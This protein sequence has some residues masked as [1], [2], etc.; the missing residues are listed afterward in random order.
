VPGKQARRGEHPAFLRSSI[1]QTQVTRTPRAPA[2][3]LADLPRDPKTREQRHLTLSRNGGSPLSRGRHWDMTPETWIASD[4][5]LRSGHDPYD[6]LN[7]ASP[8]LV[9]LEFIAEIR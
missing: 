1:K 9:P 3:H 7:V 5:H 4:L 2:S 8:W 6:V